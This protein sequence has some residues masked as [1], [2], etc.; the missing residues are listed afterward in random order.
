MG[1]KVE[2]YSMN[3]QNKIKIIGL[4]YLIIMF[5]GVLIL[6]NDISLNKIGSFSVDTS[7]GLFILGMH[8]TTVV[9][10]VLAIMVILS[11]A[12]ISFKE[13]K[14][15]L[16]LFVI[17]NIFITILLVFKCLSNLPSFGI[18]GIFNGV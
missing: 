18:G 3:T 2:V 13:Y 6:G 9:N 11:T 5:I 14:Y 1:V 17:S 4:T 15:N 12:Y 16:S 10:L 7:I 8:L